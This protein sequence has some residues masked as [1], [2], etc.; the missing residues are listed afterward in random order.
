MTLISALQANPLRIHG[1]V[2]AQLKRA[3]ENLQPHTALHIRRRTCAV[4]VSVS[5]TDTARC[6]DAQIMQLAFPICH[7]PTVAASKTKRAGTLTPQAALLVTQYR[8][9]GSC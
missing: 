9:R 4:A 3:Q 1:S 2:Q 7:R 8:S 5:V 6:Y